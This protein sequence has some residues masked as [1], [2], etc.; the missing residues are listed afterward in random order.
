MLLGPD[1]TFNGGVDDG[2]IVRVNPRGTGLSYSGYIGGDAIDSAVG[3]AADLAG[4]VYVTGVTRSY[5]NSFPVS[6]GPDLTFNARTDAYVLEIGAV[7]DEIVC[8]TGTVD[9]GVSPV[10]A[11][12]LSIN[13]TIGDG[14]RVLEASPDTALTIAMDRS[15]AGPDPTPFVL[16][17]WAGVPNGTTVSP[18]PINLGATCFPTP[19]DIGSNPQPLQIWN[20]LGRQA[21][22]GV[23]RRPSTAA[24]SIVEHLPGGVGF[25]ITVTFQ[26]L[27]LDNGSA[28]DQP[29]SLTNAIVLLVE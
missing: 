10:P 11:S 7:P 1:L 18:Q 2:F 16:Y 26:G 25:P 21:R 6:V 4:N 13:D 15:P 23:P 12:V 28:A 22:L 27:I 19:L 14:C 20:N 9:L 5:E 8:R 24:P 3:V 17:A 29:G